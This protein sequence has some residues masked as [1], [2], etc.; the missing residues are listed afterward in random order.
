MICARL[1][2]AGGDDDQAVAIESL[3]RDGIVAAAQFGLGDDLFGEIGARG[4]EDGQRFGIVLGLRDQVGG[5]LGRV[6]AFAGDDN[7]RGTGEHVDGAIEGDETLGRGDVE[8]AGADDFVDARDGLRFHRPARQ[9]RA[10]R[11]GDRT[12]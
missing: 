4:D 3:A 12:P 2:H 8:I 10:R 1:V 7:L 11:R 6:A 9:R 5:D